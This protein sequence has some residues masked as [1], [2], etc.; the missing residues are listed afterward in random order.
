MFEIWRSNAAF[1]LCVASGGIVLIPFA[2]SGLVSRK[3]QFSALALSLSV[4]AGALNAAIELARQSDPSE[5]ILDR[6]IGA[7]VVLALACPIV[8]AFLAVW[9]ADRSALI[10]AAVSTAVVATF[11][12]V[13]PL[14]VL[15]V[16]CT[17]GD[18]L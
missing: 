8:G 9:C 6:D 17:S 18:C 5:N 1:L 12:I 2:A 11:V 16:H 10:R 14:F 13:A 7:I 15:A 3:M 4:A